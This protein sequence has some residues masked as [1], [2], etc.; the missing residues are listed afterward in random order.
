M[1]IGF[2]LDVIES[3][4]KTGPFLNEDVIDI[5]D[6]GYGMNY[7]EKIIEKDLK[8]IENHEKDDINLLIEL[9]H[10]DIA[11]RKKS[12]K[13]LDDDETRLTFSE[14]KLD[15]IRNCVIIVNKLI[16]TDG[17]SHFDT[18]FQAYLEKTHIEEKRTNTN[19][20][21]IHVLNFSSEINNGAIAEI[22]IGNNNKF[23]EDIRNILKRNNIGC[24]LYNSAV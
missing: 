18:D 24:N 20:V 12:P 19:N 15:L 2:D 10:A 4:C 21:E 8:F 16:D 9:L 11:I 14:D 17:P 5:V 13:Y 22:I 23:E 3:L 1:C 7:F 6:I